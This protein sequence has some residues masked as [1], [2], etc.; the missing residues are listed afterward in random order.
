MYIIFE[1]CIL[2]TNHYG[3][4]YMDGDGLN[5]DVCGT[6]SVVHDVPDY[7]LQQIAIAIA[8]DKKYI[9]LGGHQ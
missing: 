7:A 3:A 4:I 1:D 9:E 5:F 2:N 8:E 6:A